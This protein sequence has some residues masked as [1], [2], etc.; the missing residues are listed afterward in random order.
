MIVADT[1]L[2]CEPLKERPSSAVLQWMADHH[3]EVA[4]TVITVQGLRYGVERLP[5]G[6]KKTELSDQVESLLDSVVAVLPYDEDAA[7]ETARIM[8][9]LKSQGVNLG[10]PEDVQIAGIAIVRGL[11][12]ATRNVKHLGQAGVV[13]IINPWDGATGQ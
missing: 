5:D 1:N 6:R 9:R 8:A 3:D 7:R 12:V 10:G 4:V 13:Q 2:V 11:P